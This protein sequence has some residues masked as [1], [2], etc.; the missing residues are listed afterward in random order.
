M[1]AELQ[2]IVNEDE[3]T[4][5]LRRVYSRTQ[6]RP[7]ALPPLVAG[8]TYAC[9]LYLVDR[10]GAYKVH[11]GAAGYEPRCRIGLPGDDA[12]VA[13]EP[14]SFAQIANG[15]SFDLALTTTE[16]AA[17]LA[18]SVRPAEF[19][20]N[21]TTPAALLK[22]AYRTACTL[23]P[24]LFD[25]AGDIPTP[26]S[27]YLTAAQVWRGHVRHF[28]LVTTLLGGSSTALNGQ[29]TLNSKVSAGDW[30]LVYLP[31]TKDLLLY[32]AV[33]GDAGADSAYAIRAAD[34]PTALYYALREHL[35]RD[36]RP[37]VYNST[38]A[39]YHQLVAL[40]A[41]GLET[42]ALGPAFTIPTS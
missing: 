27:A 33:A 35:G 28:P 23:V 2:F 37:A 1:P 10:T 24:A 8:V 25:P 6:L 32:Q 39:A 14:A 12:L 30:V 41:A 17:F 16:L 40:G 26:V 29:E 19:E 34:Q 13:I 4:L 11:S 38:Q 5:S 21:Y 36:G 15:W 22:C 31:A 20:L 9:E 7:F 3:Q 42:L 18:D